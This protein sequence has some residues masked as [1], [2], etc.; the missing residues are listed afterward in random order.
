MT[1]VDTS[2]WVE[3]FRGRPRAAPMRRLLADDEVSTH[4]FVIGELALG[5]LGTR[6]SS[7]L[8]DM[9]LLPLR[10]DVAHA[11]VLAL[12]RT[13]SLAGRGIGW[14]DAHL[15]A[16]SLAGSERLWT[17]DTK[18]AAAARALGLAFTP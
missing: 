13:R 14:V 17:F 2:V 5:N 6:Q 15:L 7:V 4:A 9:A 10:P 12:A 18:L 16:A 3:H 11:D 1:L 8:A